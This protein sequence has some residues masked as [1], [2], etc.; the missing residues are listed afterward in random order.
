MDTFP[1]RGFRGCAP[2]TTHHWLGHA[3]ISSRS[4]TRLL[5]R[6]QLRETNVIQ[7]LNFCAHRTTAYDNI[8][9]R[10]RRDGAARGAP[11]RRRLVI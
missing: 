3:A 4:M 1:E 9:P 5:A 11:S 10:R 2:N 7:D 8:V 6:P